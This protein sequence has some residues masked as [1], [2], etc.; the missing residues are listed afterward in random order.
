MGGAALLLTVDPDEFGAVEDR[1]LDVAAEAWRQHEPPK[2][3]NNGPQAVRRFTG[4]IPVPGE[5]VL[6]ALRATVPVEAEPESPTRWLVRAR[7][8][9]S[10]RRSAWGRTRGC[11]VRSSRRI[12]PPRGRPQGVSIEL[13][14]PDAGVVQPGRR[15]VVGGVVLV[16]CVRRVRDA[17]RVA[18]GS[19]VGVR[20]RRLDPPH[21]L[22]HPAR[23]PRD[24]PRPG[25]AVQLIELVIRR[26]T[27]R[28]Q[29]LSRRDL[30]RAAMATSTRDHL[31]ALASAVALAILVVGGLP[32]RVD[33]ASGPSLVLSTTRLPIGS[34]IVAST[35]V[36]D[37]SRCPNGAVGWTMAHSR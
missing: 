9:T 35:A 34:D 11:S 3:H 22:S 24:Q 25:V 29:R 13:P 1:R 5:A 12:G 37:A 7:F 14:R 32:A 36:D 33:A 8:D 17:G 30:G 2:E 31:G 4:E 16:D 21:R 23:R 28:A 26:I 6:S 10:A 15:L 27:L 18:G 20:V 19:G